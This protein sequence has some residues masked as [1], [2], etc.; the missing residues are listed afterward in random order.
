MKMWGLSE[1]GI[2][3]RVAGHDYGAPRVWSRYGSKHHSK[4]LAPDT[5]EV[6]RR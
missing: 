2:D 1:G 4:Y 6:S 3:H 5:V